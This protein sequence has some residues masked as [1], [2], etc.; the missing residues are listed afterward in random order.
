VTIE[1]STEQVHNGTYAM[2][3]T[4]TSSW[5]VNY[6]SGGQTIQQ[7]NPIAV[8]GGTS[9]SFVGWVY[10]PSTA[11]RVN[12]ARLRVAWYAASD[13]SGSQITTE[14]ADVTARD[15][16]TYAWL[17]D[18]APTN[19]TCAQLRLFIQTPTSGS[20]DVGPTYFDN[21]MFYASNAN[22]ITLRT[23]TTKPVPLS[24]L[25]A[26]PVLGLV[27]LGGLAAMAALGIGAVLVRRRR[28]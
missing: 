26:L 2:K 1:R 25:A 23:I 11:T 6:S 28:G 10:I 18:T 8:T 5:P 15:A 14:D 27:A 21:I 4:G 7:S 12:L 19:A 20:G 16:W 3:V 22:A 24:P 13:C 17:Y 9:Y